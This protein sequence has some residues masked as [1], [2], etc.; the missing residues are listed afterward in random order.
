MDTARRGCICT[1]EDVGRDL[2]TNF[3]HLVL[4]DLLGTTGFFWALLPLAELGSGR[5]DINYKIISL[6]WVAKL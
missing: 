5:D 6:T 3:F 4:G 1:P 2:L